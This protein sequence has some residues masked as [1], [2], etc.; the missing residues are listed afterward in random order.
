MTKTVEFNGCVYEQNPN[1]GYYFKKT[2]RNADRRGTIQLHRAVWEYYNGTIP[3]GCHIHHIDG[4]KDN[5][6]ITNLECISAKEHL[7]MHSKRLMEDE[8]YKEKNRKQLDEARELA[9]EW[10]RSA[11]GIEWHRKHTEE[12]L[13]KAWIKTER[14]CEYCGRK[15]MGTRRAMYCSDK[16]GNRARKN[17]KIKTLQCPQCGKEFTTYSGKQKYCSASCRQEAE[18]EKRRK[19]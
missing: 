19:Q 9:S 2:T 4:D 6:D 11:E 7:S 16:C 18:N 15:F 14:V 12:S 1:S 8:S 5:N 3:E 17:V 10:H 13:G